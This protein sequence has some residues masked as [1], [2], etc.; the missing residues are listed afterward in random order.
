MTDTVTTGPFPT[1]P[2]QVTAGSRPAGGTVMSLRLRLAT[3]QA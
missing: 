3:G 2:A 1:Q